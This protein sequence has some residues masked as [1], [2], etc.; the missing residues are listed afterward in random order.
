MPKD[1]TLANYQW[2]RYIYA[3]DT[4]HLEYLNKAR[5]CNAY[6]LGDQWEEGVLSMLR[7][8]Q[9]PALTINK[10]LGTMASIFGEQIEL[11]NEI[12][13]K[14]KYGAPSGNADLLTK[15]FRYI[16]DQNQLD[17]A[18]TE[19]FIDGTITSRGY[20]DVRM[21]FEKNVAGDVKITNMNPKNVLPDPDADMA[22]P[23]TWN[24]VMITRW[25]TADD[26]EVLYNKT[27]ADTLR[28]RGSS[29][30]YGFDSIDTVQDRFGGK[31]SLAEDHDDDPSVA[32]YI[33]C[34]ERQYKKLSKIVSV[35]N[36]RT[37]D[38]MV[39]PYSWS[40]DEVAAYVQNQQ[41]AGTPA[42]MVE[43]IGHRIR[44]TVTADD[45][46]LHDDWSPYKHFT[47]V[48]YFPFFR[49]GATM[50]LVENL[51]DPQD[52]L[53]KTASQELHVVNT[54]ANSGWKV[55]RGSLMNMTTDE[56]EQLG[57]RT[58]LVMELEDVGDA[59]KITPNQIPTGLDQL[60]RKGE[61]YIKSVSM[62]GDAQMGMTRAD[63]S[64]DQIEA[65]NVRG[66]IGLRHPMDALRRSDFWLARNI[67][68]LVQEYYSDPRVMTITK[69]ELTGDQEDVKINWPDPETGEIQND[70][71]LGEYD[72]KVVSQPAK[73]TL[74]ETQFQQAV[75]L[76]EKLG[77]D[78]P[79]EFLVQNSN[80]L[81]KTKLIEAL[82]ERAQ[83]SE[84]QQKQKME[85][86]AGQLELANLKAEAARM[87]ADTVLKQAKAVQTLAQA[88][89]ETEGE[90]G[91]AEKAQQ[92]MALKQQEGDQKFQL[93]EREH[94]QEMQMER[95]K[96]ALELELRDKE[97]RIQRATQI[98]QARTQAKQAKQPQG[99]DAA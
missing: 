19:M 76:R 37:G 71:T 80:L 72:I 25:Y 40:A 89:S 84:A 62:R 36:P 87:E 6:F 57:A 42:I 49:Y 56:L 28:V 77:V 65:N 22:D 23:E 53:N 34:V 83:S 9:R 74:E 59:E 12:A 11:R 35:V 86:M 29:Q 45:L 44:W 79:D 73:Q 14:G 15:V 85:L 94:Q 82:R 17:W 69:S 54:T 39:A 18:R 81:D 5:R 20:L 2:K 52:L 70:I 41:Q 51:I 75:M 32:R 46:V 55:K 30:L 63:V 31:S 88:K 10:I 93:K 64:A 47:I 48:P 50:G 97:A 13:F 78:I 68:S 4:G 27:D 26:I 60:S 43:D 1:A 99:A 3:R 8:E 96:H 58:G 16:S 91:E 67:L 61:N 95:E 38:R 33:R 98:L 90:V 7:A 24:E 21:D 66:E 92:E